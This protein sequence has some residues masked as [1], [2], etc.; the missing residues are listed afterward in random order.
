LPMRLRVRRYA[1][2]AA[3]SRRSKWPR[4]RKSPSLWPAPAKS[5]ATTATLRGRS[6]RTAMSASRR[7]PALPWQKMTAGRT[8]AES[9]GSNREHLRTLFLS[10]MS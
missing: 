7:H 10:L 8:E 9:R 1:T 2:T 6:V 5:K 4:E 3:R